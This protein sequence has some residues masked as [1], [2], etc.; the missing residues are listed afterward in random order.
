MMPTGQDRLPGLGEMEFISALTDFNLLLQSPKHYHQFAIRN[1]RQVIFVFI[2]KT[3]LDCLL[4]VRCYVLGIKGKQDRHVVCLPGAS[5]I[6]ALTFHL[7]GPWYRKVEGGDSQEDEWDWMMSEELPA[8]KL[9]RYFHIK[10]VIFSRIY[11]FATIHLGPEKTYLM[12]F[13]R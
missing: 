10:Q 12:A 9:V 13:C 1:I 3:F 2:Q 6:E 7:V 11:E 5:G 8:L 4:H